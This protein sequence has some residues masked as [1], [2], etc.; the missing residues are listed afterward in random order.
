MGACSSA[1]DKD[2]LHEID[3]YLKSRAKS[4]LIGLGYH[5][6]NVRLDDLRHQKKLNKDDGEEE[7]E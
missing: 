1:D 3:L 5:M 4:Y 6:P 7:P 2:K